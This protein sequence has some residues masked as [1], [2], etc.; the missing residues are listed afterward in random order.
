MVRSLCRAARPQHHRLRWLH[1]GHRGLQRPLQRPGR[2]PAAAG[3]AGQE[4]RRLGGVQGPVQPGG[5]V[6]DLQVQGKI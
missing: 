2:A 6:R 3:Q 4:G 5:G 1:H